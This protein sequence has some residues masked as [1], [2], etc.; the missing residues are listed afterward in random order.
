MNQI[1]LTLFSFEDNVKHSSMRALLH[2]FVLAAASL[3]AQRF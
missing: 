2:L 1:P 3:L